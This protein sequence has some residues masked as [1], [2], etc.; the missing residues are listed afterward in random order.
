M[1]FVIW[2]EVWIETLEGAGERLVEDG[3]ASDVSD[4]S[5][6]KPMRQARQAPKTC[7]RT[8]VPKFPLGALELADWMTAE[9][10]AGSAGAKAA[11]RLQRVFETHG[12]M[13]P[14]EDESRIWHDL[15]LQLPKSGVAIAKHRR[16]RAETDARAHN[17]VGKFACGIAVAG[18]GE[19]MLGS[20][21]I[22]HLARDYF[23]IP[24]GATMP[25]AQ[26][27]SIEADHDRRSHRVNVGICG[28]LGTQPRDT[29]AD[30]AGSIAHCA[31]IDSAADGQ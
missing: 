14:V 16:R 28:S 31:G 27:A 10:V 20:I 6:V 19:A 5:G 9:V 22:E 2:L 25:A 15:T 26:I 30:A 29:L 11:R 18:K 24:F 1:I 7:A 13:K 3:G 4:M 8:T 12:D 21:E 17:R 23:E